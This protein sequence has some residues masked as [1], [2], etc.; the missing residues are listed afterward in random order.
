MRH[1]PKTGAGCALY[2]KRKQTVE[3]VIRHHQGGVQFQEFLLRGVTPVHAEWSLVTPDQF[4]PYY[5]RFRRTLR[6][7]P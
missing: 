7:H 6:S 3:P 2:S 5:S 1:R 4:F